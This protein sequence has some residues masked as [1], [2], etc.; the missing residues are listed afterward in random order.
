MIDRGKPAIRY[1]HTPFIGHAE[2]RHV[3]RFTPAQ[4]NRFSV[5]CRLN[6]GHHAHIIA[7]RAGFV[8]G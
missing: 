8:K 4:G 7:D 5:V 6:I 1:D 2:Y 3:A